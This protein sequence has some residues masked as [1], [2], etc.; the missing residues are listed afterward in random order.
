MELPDDDFAT[1]PP[2]SSVTFEFIMELDVFELPTGS[3]ATRDRGQQATFPVQT[4]EYIR[5]YHGMQ[6]F[7]VGR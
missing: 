2:L 4:L 7:G 3:V 1:F 6:D 5:E